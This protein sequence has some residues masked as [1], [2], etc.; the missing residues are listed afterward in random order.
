VKSAVKVPSCCDQVQSYALSGG[1][2]SD[3]LAVRA[4]GLGKSAI[5][6]CTR[7]H[8]ACVHDERRNH[9]S[10]HGLSEWFREEPRSQSPGPSGDG[11]AIGGHDRDRYGGAV[12]GEHFDHVPATEAGHLDIGEHDIDRRETA[13]DDVESFFRTLGLGNATELRFQY[14][15]DQ[16]PNSDVVINDK[17]RRHVTSPNVSRIDGVSHRA[18]L[19]PLFQARLQ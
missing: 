8:G 7:S 5:G 14:A 9:P 3:K 13:F 16:P 19:Q 2:F 11:S 10:Q 6:P 17:G 15:M 12:F 1:L 18:S 4:G